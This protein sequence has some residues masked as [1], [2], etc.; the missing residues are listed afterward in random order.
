[1][2]INFANKLK[3]TL[4]KEAGVGAEVQDMTGTLGKTP[5][6]DRLALPCDESE[7]GDHTK[8]KMP[9][10]KRKWKW[11]S[12]VYKSEN[13]LM[14]EK[15]KTTSR[16][17]LSLL[18]EL[19]LLQLNRVPCPECF[20]CRHHCHCHHYCLCQLSHKVSIL[21]IVSCP[22]D[23]AHYQ[24]SLFQKFEQKNCFNQR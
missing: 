6:P 4:Y 23:S 7:S 3:H 19:S 10:R 21:I 1:M 5:G 18:A 14:K 15:V 24:L 8:V 9:W 22:G 11:W 17:E 12:C 13:A 16:Q 2:L 20:Q